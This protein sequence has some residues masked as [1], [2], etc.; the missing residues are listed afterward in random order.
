MTV[1]LVVCHG[2][3]YHGSDIKKRFMS[4]Y[5]LAISLALVPSVNR[6]YQYGCVE[7]LAAFLDVCSNVFAVLTAILESSFTSSFL[8]SAHE[9]ICYPSCNYCV[10]SEIAYCSCI[11]FGCFLWR[12]PLIPK[13]SIPPLFCFSSLPANCFI[14][15]PI[16]NEE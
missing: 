2:L 11:D 3:P 10:I 7:G 4:F 12:C 8:C 14:R 15:K 16:E 6:Y 13:Y 1:N 9:I 5:V